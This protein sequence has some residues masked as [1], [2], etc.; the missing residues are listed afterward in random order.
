MQCGF[1][2]IQDIDYGSITEQGEKEKTHQA[3]IADTVG[4]GSAIPKWSGIHH[5]LLSSITES[6]PPPFHRKY[7]ILGLASI[8]HCTRLV[9]LANQYDSWSLLTWFSGICYDS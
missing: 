1:E 3:G 8:K 6:I 7:N 4:T 9:P 2:T 5:S